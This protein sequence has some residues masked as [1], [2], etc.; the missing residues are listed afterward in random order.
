MLRTNLHSKTLYQT[1]IPL[2]FIIYEG[3]FSEAGGGPK[4]AW[5]IW[6]PKASLVLTF[7]LYGV[8]LTVKPA[9]HVEASTCFSFLTHSTLWIRYHGWIV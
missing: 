3:N 6:L 2:S 8:I 4:Y 7:L 5:S 1:V 9:G